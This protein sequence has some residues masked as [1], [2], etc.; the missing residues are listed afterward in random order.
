MQLQWSSELELGIPVIDS[1]HQ[2]IVEYI[3]SVEQANHDQEK[4][5]I[6]L[7]ELIDYTISHFAF[8][9]S[10]MEEAGYTFA[11]AHKKVHQLF[12]R[13]VETFTT[14][15][16]AGEDITNDLLIVLKSWLVNHIKRDDKDYSDIVKANLH[17]A[18]TRTKARQG[19]WFNRLFG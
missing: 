14:R 11:K 3:N 5:R 1:Q 18:T 7:N 19:T 15:L 9:E 16:D 10:L 6:I 12:T 4:M 2:R 8:E 13:R 17:A